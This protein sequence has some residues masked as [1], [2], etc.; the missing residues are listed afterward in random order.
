MDKELILILK[1]LLERTLITTKELKDETGLTIRQ[2]TYRINKINEMLK[3]LNIPPISLKYNKDIILKPETREGILEIIQKYESEK[4]YYLS[5]D[6]R[7]AFMY[8]TLFINLDY[9][10][11]NYFINSM[12][13]SRSSVLMDFK[14]LGQLLNENGI[15]I[16]N[17][18]TEGYYL[19]GS[20]MEIR[21]LMIKFVINTLS[22]NR[23]CKIFNLFIKEYKLDNYQ[24]SKEIISKLAIKHNITFVEDRLQEF[25]YIFIFLKARLL[26]EK[27]IEYETLKIS[28]ISVIRLMKEYNFTEDLLYSFENG[29]KIKSFDANYISAWII[30]ISVGNTKDKT[31]DISIITKIVIRIMARF[32]SLSGFHYMNYNEIFEQLYSHFRPAYYRLLFKLPIYNPLCEKVKEEYKELYKL[33]YETMKPFSEL[34]DQEIPEDELAYLTIHFGAILFNGNEPVTPQKK[35]AL[36]VCSAGIGSSAILY[37]EL[38]VLFPELHFLVPIELSKLKDISET[39]DII[40]TSNFSA[41]LME[42][43]KPLIKVSPVMTLKEKSQVKREVY[44]LLG[45]TLLKQPRVE[46]VMDIIK[47]YSKVTSE[48]L[49]H[50]EL[51]SY[52]SQLEN[53]NPKNETGLLLSDLTNENLIRLNVPAQNWEE[54]IRNSAL[55]LLENDKIAAPYIDAM[56]STAKESG[57]YI[58]ITKHVALPHARPEAGAKETAMGIAVLE[59]PIEFGNKG[60]DPVKYVFSL[61]AVDHESHLQVMAEFLEL[62]EKEEF[63]KILDKAKSPGEIMDFI[64]S[65]ESK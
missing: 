14:D 40:F 6:E 13:V 10:S 34:F 65:Y 42:I 58:V 39:V 51:Q 60:N 3:H 21:R 5:K 31:E 24:V 54:A 25:I 1:L 44:M 37:T 61:S 16:K 36:I 30:G 63:Y 11:L 12:K 49:L 59:H 8:L 50:H 9:L 26:S 17:N 18:R 22:I 52:F 53:Y 46:E 4:N 62:L 56:I 47:R 33:V 23:D 27:T 43:E 48:N 29:N 55:A 38:K 28:N 15:D 41:E 7:L 2:I 19:T 20:E 57:P 45:N 35:K 32:Q 64:K